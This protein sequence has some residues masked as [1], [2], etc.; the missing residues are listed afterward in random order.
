MTLGKSQD[1]D[2][3]DAHTDFSFGFFTMHYIVSLH[4]AYRTEVLLP[5]SWESS[6]PFR[7]EFFGETIF[8][9]T[10]RI[11]SVTDMSFKTAK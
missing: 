4:I 6:S 2:Y 5:V 3:G 7:L 8:W 1:S 10:N 9:E 11:R